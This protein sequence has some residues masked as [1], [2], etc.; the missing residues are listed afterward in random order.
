MTLPSP[1]DLRLVFSFPSNPMNKSGLESAAMTLLLSVLL[2]MGAVQDQ[3]VITGRVTSAMDAVGFAD[4]PV[5]LVG[6]LTGPAANAATS[7]PL[8]I[9]EIAE[10]SG[11]RQTSMNTD[12][13][14]RFTFRNLA[15]GQY[16]L[17]VQKEGYL[18]AVPTATG[19]FSS[20]ATASV[21]V[22]AG[23]APYD[24]R[25]QLLRGVV[26]S[27]RV[28]DARGQPVPNASVIAY[29]LGYR[30]G[31]E[32]L[33]QVSSRRT[34]DRGE[35]RFFGQAPGK[36]YLAAS[37]GAVVPGPPMGN[38]RGPASCCKTF[39]PS[40]SD[41]QS[42]VLLDLTEGDE[43]T[44]RNIDIRAFE[45]FKISGRVIN[46]VP[47][48]N[49]QPVT[50]SFVLVPNSYQL[51]ADNNYYSNV[52]VSPDGL[53]ELQGVPAGSYELVATVPG[54]AGRSY[55]GRVRV[56][57]GSRDVEGVT[58]SISP[59]RE[60]RMR[61]LVDGQVAVGSGMRLQLRSKESFL[62]VGLAGP[63]ITGD[64]SGTYVF[65]DVPDS[66]YSIVPSGIPANSYVSD[67]RAGA[68]SVYDS[69]LV[70]LGGGSPG[71]IDVLVSSGAQSVRGV[72]RSAEGGPVASA[73]VVLAPPPSRRQN[74][75][76]YRTFRTNADGE[77]TLNNIPPGDYK[78][79]AWQS[80][81][82]TAHMNAAFMAKYES[83][84]RAITLAGGGNPSFDLTIIPSDVGR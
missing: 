51:D 50:P 76:L 81:P 37:T 13:G 22:T 38:L 83:L 19:G 82:N 1:G 71:T 11:T 20:M 67:I 16:M 5:L 39:Y 6:P 21:T 29:Q 74:S 8:M 63:S 31:R 73:N 9:Q 48:P 52:S 10:G 66:V 17:K 49:A 2:A 27:G 30:D 40:A 79:F 65:A 4:V 78:L 7:N 58:V 68:N 84:G 34:D 23:A 64:A 36:Y 60:V 35:Y 69:G 46:A 54:L 42:A 56:D 14:G 45:T 3:G 25:L 12:S 55:P 44:G 70:L 24:V 61:I 18:S 47:A 43:S 57:V 41:T 32:T 53:F 26:F 33:I 15:S 59:G 77:F 75:Q 72:V 28:S 62:S 80:L